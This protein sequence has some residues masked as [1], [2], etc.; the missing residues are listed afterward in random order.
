MPETNDDHIFY[1]NPTKFYPTVERG[2][3]I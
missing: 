1:R 2:D 3:G